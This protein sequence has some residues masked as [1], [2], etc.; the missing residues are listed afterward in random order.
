[1]TRSESGCE[2]PKGTLRVGV[3]GGER[4]ASGLWQCCDW[5]GRQDRPRPEVMGKHQK[6]WTAV[7]LFPQTSRQDENGADKE[8]WQEGRAE[9]A[10]RGGREIFTGFR[11]PIHRR[12][13]RTPSAGG[14]LCFERKENVISSQDCKGRMKEWIQ[15]RDPKN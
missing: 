9:G 15:R 4:V 3:A 6:G 1:M 14:R 11:N 12:E 5:T 7:C 13:D 8:N 10:G 2:W